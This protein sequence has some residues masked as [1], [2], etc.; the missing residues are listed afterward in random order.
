MKLLILGAG[1]RLGAALMREFRDQF[2]I[3][4][5]SHAELDLSELNAVRE[6]LRAIDFGVVINAAGFTNVDLC[7][8]QPDRAFRVNAEAPRVIAEICREKN[9]RLIH[10]STDYVF[11][12]E[13]H[14]AYNE[15]DEANPI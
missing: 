5:F 11:G 6:K 8:T 14:E 10:F 7:E 15:D 1:G 13:K 2:D 12:G 4:G 9:A 3:T